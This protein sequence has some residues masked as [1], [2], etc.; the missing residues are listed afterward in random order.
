MRKFCQLWGVTHHTGI[1][2]SPTGQAIVERANQTIK[3]YLQKFR[4]V[5]DVQERVFKAL[6]VLNY[7]CLFGDS[8]FVPA[9]LHAGFSKSN[10]PVGMKVYYKDLSTG[11]WKGP[12]EVQFI[13]K[14]YMCVLTPSGAQWVPARW[15]KAVLE[16]QFSES[17]NEE[18]TD[19][20]TADGVDCSSSR[21]AENSVQP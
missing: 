19:H 7:L 6:F 5:A 14:G 2:H 1:P 13:G 3:R 10:K 9:K 17:K 16:L 15:T 8:E 21:P 12:A 18:A 11:Q 4:D 20:L